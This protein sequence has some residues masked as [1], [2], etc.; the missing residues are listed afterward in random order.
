MIEKKAKKMNFKRNGL[1]FYILT[2]AI[3][4]IQFCIFYIGVNFNSI[5]LAFKDYDAVTGKYSFA[6]FDNFKRF[7]D[8]IMLGAELTWAIKNSLKLW[9]TSLVVG[10][11]FALL[12]SYYICKK[13]FMYN[14][15]RVLL[16]LP[17]MLS[18]IVMSIIFNYILGRGFT[19]MGMPD[20]LNNLDTQFNTI[21]FY[22]IW[23]GFGSSILLYSGAMGQ[24]STEMM[25]AAEVDG[26][27]SLRVFIS[28]I[29]PSIFP[30]ISTFLITGIAGIFTNQAGLYNF[31][32]A[33][34]STSSYTLGYYLF[35]EVVGNTSGGMVTYP[36]AA[37]AGLILTLVA[38]PI[39]L[40]VKWLLEKFGPSED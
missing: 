2:F 15:L 11:T 13:K 18:S 23:I 10:V 37:A 3:P 40:L 20:L 29:L 27:S 1:I 16:F 31:F 25:E 28:I 6:Y 22:N 14:T 4:V 24:V 19:S 33:G 9:F 21:V 8:N 7:F 26:A 38:A 12:F 36:Y 34:A 35:V 5:L 39:T 32:G 17:S 30:T